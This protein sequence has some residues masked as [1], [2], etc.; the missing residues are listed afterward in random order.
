MPW[1]M[2]DEIT[3][4]IPAIELQQLMPLGNATFGKLTFAYFLSTFL[5]LFYLQRIAKPVSRLANV[6]EI[7]STWQGNM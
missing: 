3:Y 7:L 2:W 1:K 4:P 5:G 6:L